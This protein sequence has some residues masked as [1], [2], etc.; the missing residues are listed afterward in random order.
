MWNAFSQKP[1]LRP[2]AAEPPRIPLDTRNPATS[3]TAARSARMDFSEADRID[4]DEM[5]DILWLAI[6]QT[7]PPVP[8][9][10]FFSR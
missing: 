10:S 8:V 7:P 1:D 3:A 4:D 9:R 2:Y 6:R 5:N